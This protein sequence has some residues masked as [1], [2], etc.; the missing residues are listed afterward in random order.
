MKE[1][2]VI[3][4]RS[5]VVVYA[6]MMRMFAKERFRERGEVLLK[7]GWSFALSLTV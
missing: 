7:V 1:H 4:T 6:I 5:L 2:Y 3:E